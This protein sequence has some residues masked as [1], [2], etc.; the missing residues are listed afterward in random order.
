MSSAVAF[1]AT[2]PLLGWAGA[3]VAPLTTAAA[4]LSFGAA[5]SAFVQVPL[6][7]VAGAP[8]TKRELP[9]LVMMALSGAAM[10]PTALAWVNRRRVGGLG[11]L[12]PPPG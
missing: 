12:E 10:A 2:L 9:A 6:V 8:L 5:L 4:L 1:G 11:P 7:R 3:G